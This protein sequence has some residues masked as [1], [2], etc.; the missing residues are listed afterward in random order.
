MAR[1][2]SKFEN[3]QHFNFSK[4]DSRLMNNWGLSNFE[5][6]MTIFK[7]AMHYLWFRLSKEERC[8]VIKYLTTWDCVSIYSNSV[9]IAMR[10]FYIAHS[11][12]H[13]F[14]IYDQN[15]FV[16]HVIYVIINIGTYPHA[17][18]MLY[19]LPRPRELPINLVCTNHIPGSFIVMK[20]KR[21]TQFV[22]INRSCCLTC[23][24][25]WYLTSNI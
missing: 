7:S 13:K 19:S 9:S 22:L 4:R 2:C 20:I 3:S 12:K 17:T 16:I 24:P 10:V 6:S 15:I 25:I 8:I 23:S 11:E 1:C 21:M 14:T 5:K 18:S